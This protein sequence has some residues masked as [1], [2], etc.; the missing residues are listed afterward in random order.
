MR[1]S[2]LGGFSN[3]WVPKLLLTPIKI[4]IFSPQTAKICPKYAFLVIFNQI[5]A[6]FAHFV[7]CPNK[8]QCEQG[9]RWVFRYAGNNTLA[10]PSKN[11]DFLPKNDQIWPEIG[12]FAKPCRL[13]W[14][15]VGG[16]VCGC[17]T[18]A[19]LRKTPIYFTIYY[20][21]ISKTSDPS[22]K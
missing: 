11:W 8:N 14:C 6:F 5:L 19:V 12:I 4:R 7:P 15:P 13:I 18:Q 16:L 3:M 9:A 22:F 20:M 2:C 1:T 17:S 10:F 21:S